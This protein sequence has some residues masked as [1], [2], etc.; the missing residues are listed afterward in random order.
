MLTATVRTEQ[1]GV[2]G[3]H[4]NIMVLREPVPLE[5]VVLL[6]VLPRIEVLVQELVE[7]EHIEVQH[8]G[9][10]HTD[11]LDQVEAVLVVVLTEARA[12]LQEVLVLT[13]VLE[14]LVD[15]RQ[16][17]VLD[18]P[19]LAHDLHQAVETKFIN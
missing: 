1:A 11:L 18:H 9:L 3:L 14:A 4:Q 5:E 8:L 10:V 6:P 19:A 12:D 13:G 7:A 2:Q 15:L 16:D 17:L